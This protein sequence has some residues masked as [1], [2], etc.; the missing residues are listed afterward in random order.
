MSANDGRRP[1]HSTAWAVAAN[2]NDGT[3]TSPVSSDARST[4]INPVVHD[5]TAT[6]CRTPR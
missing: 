5:A 2:V 3:I 6:Q 1:F 4:S